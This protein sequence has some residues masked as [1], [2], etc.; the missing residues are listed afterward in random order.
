M[1]S[2]QDIHSLDE[3]TSLEESDEFVVADASD[4]YSFKRVKNENVASLTQQD[5]AAKL[6]LANNYTYIFRG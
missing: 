3:L 2:D 6:Y 5:V 1:P 4:S